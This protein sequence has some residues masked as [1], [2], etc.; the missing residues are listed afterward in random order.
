MT[1]FSII[2]AV[3][4]VLFFIC[5]SY[6]FVY[7]AVS[8]FKGR[9]SKG[10]YVFH[11]YA[12]LISARN[13]EAVIGDLIES[14]NSQLYPHEL[15]TVFVVAD[16][17]TDN[18]A[19]IAK[20]KGAIVYERFN[21]TQVGKGYALDF[22]LERIDEDYPSGFDGYFVFDADNI[23][24][25]DYVY[26]MN[27]TFSLGYDVVTGYRNSKNYGDNWIS[28]GYGLW[29]LR[30]SQFLN[31][32]RNILGVSCNIS[33]TGFVLSHRIIEKLGGW[34]YHLLTEDLEFTADNI[35]NGEKIGYCETAVLYD[36]QPTNFR[37][38]IRQRMRWSKGFFQV[39]SKHGAEL[40][41]GIFK[42][43][44]FSCYDITM[45]MAPA[46]V[47]SVAG[48]LNNTVCLMESIGNTGMLFEVIASMAQAFISGYLTFLFI[49]AVTT[50][51]EW[52][53]I[54]TTPLKKVLYI[55]TFPIFMFTYLP[56]TLAALFMKVEWKPIIHGR[57]Q[58]LSEIRQECK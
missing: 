14:I 52:N 30:E 58:K 18:T 2:N 4:G 57:S 43:K 55:F 6:Q 17:C 42:D 26:E 36:E 8:L 40:I 38:S 33:G 3:I 23:L 7:M 28:A 47:L 44:S 37:Q 56:I 49:G 41:K 24:E 1:I 16:N 34:K 51:T 5:Y 9:R 45:A 29:F 31:K 22:L 39:F 10:E 19:V 54:H 13:E 48:M 53:S 11:N 46:L 35:I 25:Q 32:P 50:L 12:V 20:N 21:K 27:R 15:I